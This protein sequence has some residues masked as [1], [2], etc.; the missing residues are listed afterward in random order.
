MSEALRP[1][2]PPRTCAEGTSPRGA[3][4]PARCACARRQRAGA[5]GDR[6][7]TL[8]RVCEADSAGGHAAG[9]EWNNAGSDAKISK[10]NEKE[11]RLGKN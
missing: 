11:S 9:L 10:P 2:S 1:S 3:R 7:E 5:L 6:R 8:A 4:G